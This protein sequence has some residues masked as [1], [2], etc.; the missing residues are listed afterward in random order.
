MNKE[1]DNFIKL[2][3]LFPEKKKVLINLV[4]EHASD[5]PITNFD[6]FFRFFS[7]F[8]RVLPTENDKELFR[9]ILLYRRMPDNDG[10]DRQTRIAHLFKE[11][12][13]EKFPKRIEEL[14]QIEI[15]ALD[16][17]RTA[18]FI[19]DYFQHPD[20]ASIPEAKIIIPAILKDPVVFDK[21]IISDAALAIFKTY[22]PEMTFLAGKNTV[23]EARAAVK[24]EMLE[25]NKIAMFSK[26]KAL[27]RHGLFKSSDKSSLPMDAAKKIAA[28][29][30]TD[31]VRKV[32]AAHPQS[33]K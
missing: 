14:F 17:E 16:T 10:T 2:L 1:P 7:E 11:Q 30:V 21:V 31:A 20:Y 22:C 25:R 18:N 27:D 6:Q 29:S 23:A 13:Y 3:E 4:L 28:D 15:L 8:K 19:A 32:K 9:A 12:L 24:T 33:K 26:L 5:F